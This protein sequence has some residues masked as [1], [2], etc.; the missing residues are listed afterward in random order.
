MT[1]STFSKRHL[2]LTLLQALCWIDVK[3]IHTASWYTFTLC[4]HSNYNRRHIVCV[5]TT[6]AASVCFDFPHTITDVQ[7]EVLGLWHVCSQGLVAF[8]SLFCVTICSYVWPS[9]HV[10]NLGWH[11]LWWWWWWRQLWQLLLEFLWEWLCSLLELWLWCTVLFFAW[12][13]ASLEFRTVASLSL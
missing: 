9:L 10:V 4:Y 8:T 11:C 1:L 3:S 13:C 5:Y 12:L 2:T 7:G 6:S